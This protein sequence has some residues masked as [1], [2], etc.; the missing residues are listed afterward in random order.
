MA[1]QTSVLRTWKGIWTRILCMSDEYSKCWS[2]RKMCLLL[3]P[4][5]NLSSFP[6]CM[7]M[8]PLLGYGFHETSKNTKNNCTWP[9]IY[10]KVTWCIYI[11]T[12][13][14]LKYVPW[15]LCI[16]CLWLFHNFL[17]ELLSFVRNSRV[18]KLWETGR[19][20][21]PNCRSTIYELELD[22]LLALL[23]ESDSCHCCM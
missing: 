19:N 14:Y 11:Y 23:P 10:P 8:S 7:L 3:F 13:I 12:H 4:K 2:T 5:N 16:A 22:C 15:F 17:V 18:H 6:F 1:I 9:C 20:Y 21:K